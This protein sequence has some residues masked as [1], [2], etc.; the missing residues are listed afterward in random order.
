MKIKNHP[1]LI[2]TWVCITCLVL[3]LSFVDGKFGFIIPTISQSVSIIGLLA[4]SYLIGGLVCLKGWKYTAFILIPYLLFLVLLETGTRIWIIHLAKRSERMLY[5][6]HFKS[7]ETLGL[8]TVYVPHHYTLYNLRPHYSTSEGTHHN[9]L[10][11]RDQRD[12]YSKNQVIRIV[13]IGGS[14]TYTIGI[15]DN[16]EIFSYG[17]EQRL[18]EYYKDALEN[19]RI[20]VVNAGMGGATSAENLLRLIFF[21]SQISPDLVVIQH[22]LNDVWPRTRANLQSDFSNYRKSWSRPQSKK[23]RSAPPLFSIDR[24][25]ISALTLSLTRKSVFLA[26]ILKRVDYSNPKKN[27]YAEEDDHPNVL[28]IGR[29]VVRKDVE[30]NI[31]YLDRNSPEYFER[32]TRYMVAICRS[33]GA[34]ILL[35]TEAYSAKAGKTRNLAMP[36]HNG[37]L[38][39]IAKE[40]Q[41]IFYDFDKEMLKDKLHMP[42]GRHVSQVGSDLKRDLF[43]GYFI[44]Q[45]IIPQ[46]LNVVKK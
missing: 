20:E 27:P 34:Q 4:L 7:P 42:D 31:A 45:D 21:V 28:S 38:A 1:T 26:F 23:I 11:L 43:F 40:E 37:L 46:L 8:E 9:R 13:F 35:A 33:M 12:L 14:T 6:D 19:Y 30:K 10:G 25:M 22:G 24:P 15:K 18:N 44:K 32:N 5:V 17:L 16:S 3:V 41:V 29:L 2:Y 39:R 36:E